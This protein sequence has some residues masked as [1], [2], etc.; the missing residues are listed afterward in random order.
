MP[1]QRW[2]L[3]VP[4][5]MQVL[6]QQ[7]S[8]AALD[9]GLRMVRAL[10]L[11]EQVAT[12]QDLAAVLRALTSSAQGGA[13]ASETLQQLAAAAAQPPQQARYLPPSCTEPRHRVQITAAVWQL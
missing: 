13:E 10:V 2:P 3:T 1:L 6:Q 4:G 8:Q 7:P 11:V 9:F 5:V 12:P